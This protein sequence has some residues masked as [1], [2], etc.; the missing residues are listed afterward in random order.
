[1]SALHALNVLVID[2]NSHMRAITVAILKSA[3]IRRTREVSDGAMALTALR[4]YP[5]DLAIVDF[6]MSPMD[7][8]EFTRLVRN[9]PDSVNPYLP[10]IMM[11]GHS[12]RSRVTE[13]RDAGVTEFVVKPVTARAIFERIQAIILRPRAFIQTDT[14][15]G[16]DRR[17]STPEGYSGPWRRNSD[18]R[19]TAAGAEISG[20]GSSAA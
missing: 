8:V 11:T 6:N 9:S 20:P 16:P 3:G 1:M 4:E 7:G 18:Q 2:D 13:A 10:I 17:R 14:Y 12:E 5:I 15:F 19:G